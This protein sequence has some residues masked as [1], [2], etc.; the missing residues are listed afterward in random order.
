M[1][2][3]ANLDNPH[4]IKQNIKRL[5][6]FLQAK[7]DGITLKDANIPSLSTKESYP[8]HHPF[9]W[10]DDAENG[11][12][13]AMYQLGLIYDRDNENQKAV[14]WYK[15]ASAKGHKEAK[16]QLEFLQEWMKKHKA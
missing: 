5:E 9:H 12:A 2:K 16:E 6:Q 1:Q 7:L 14:Y 10:I 13:E 15:K 11:D 3:L 8:K 4:Y